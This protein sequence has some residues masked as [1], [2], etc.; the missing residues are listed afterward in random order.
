MECLLN[1]HQALH[2]FSCDP[3]IEISYSGN[4]QLIAPLF[5]FL[6][7][8]EDLSL[9]FKRLQHIR[10]LLPR[11]DQHKAFIIKLQIKILH[12][13]GIW[14]HKSVKIILEIF[15]AVNIHSGNPSITEQLFFIIHMMPVEHGNG[16]IRADTAFADWKLP[17]Y[18]FPHPHLHPVKKLLIQGSTAF[19][20]KIKSISNRIM[21]HN[22]IHIL[23]SSYIKNCLQKNKDRT[24]PIGFST[25]TVLCGYKSQCTVMLKLLVKLTELSVLSH[26]DHR[27]LCFA[28]IIPYDLRIRCHFGVFPCF[29][30]YGHFNHCLFHND[31]LHRLIYLYSCPIFRTAMCF[32]IHFS[33]TDNRIPS[34]YIFMNTNTFLQSAFT[35]QYMDFSHWRR[36]S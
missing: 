2:T 33:E 16:I 7:H 13:A 3:V 29:S 8:M 9:G 34:H 27:I 18:Q 20:G 6:L 17:V 12:I 26:K 35:K 4:I 5:R 22:M 21:D 15:Q 10:V 24:S 36:L 11:K 31:P 25:G 23:F 32:T 1:Q 28:L 19:H 14:C 30:V